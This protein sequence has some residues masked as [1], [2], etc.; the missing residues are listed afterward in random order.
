MRDILAAL[1]RSRGYEHNDVGDPS[2]MYWVH[3]KLGVR[4]LLACIAHEMNCDLSTGTEG[5]DTYP[6][7]VARR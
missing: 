5:W 3:A 2:D 1:L 4:P 6:V 7:S